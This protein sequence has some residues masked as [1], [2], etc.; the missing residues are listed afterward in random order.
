M[1]PNCG[2]KCVVVGGELKDSPTVEELSKTNGNLPGE[3]NAR[4]LAPDPD[5]YPLIAGVWWLAVA[6]VLCGALPP[7]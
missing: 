5:T 1:L 6:V 7:D 4:R 2:L 3:K